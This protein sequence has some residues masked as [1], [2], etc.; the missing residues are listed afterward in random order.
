MRE[1]AR[2]LNVSHSTIIEAFK[3]LGIRKDSLN[4][5]TKIP[6][7]IP[8]GY[9]YKNRNHQTIKIKWAFVK[10]YSKGIKPKIN[11]H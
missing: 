1:I 4:N 6:G 5:S 11:T 8:F 9:N 3:R 7:Q 10:R 2:Q